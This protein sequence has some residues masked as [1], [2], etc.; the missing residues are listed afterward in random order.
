MDN[1]QYGYVCFAY[2]KNK[3]YDWC[4][5]KLTG[6]KWSHSF[7]T[8]P[9]MLGKEMLMEACGGGVSVS[10]FDIG[11]RNN[12]NQAYEVY[13]LK[14]D[15][16][17]IDSSIKNQIKELE[18]SYAFLAYPWFMW[19]Y[20]NRFLGRDIKAKDNWYQSQTTRICSQFLREF[21]EGC[22]FKSLFDGY[23]LGSA[24]PQDIYTLV[25]S[26]PDLFELIESKS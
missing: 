20:L 8:C 15:R 19:R 6:S 3:W 21:I 13:Q 12:V 17:T 4:I 25:L 2:T 7:F 9:P 24:S 11:Y 5:S 23:G 26:R 22:G 14:I 10:S 18:D 1:A 16:A